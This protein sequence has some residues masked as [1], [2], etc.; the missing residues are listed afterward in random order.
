MRCLRGFASLALALALGCAGPAGDGGSSSE[1]ES[2]SGVPSESGTEAVATESESESESETGETEGDPP[3][4]ARLL[5]TADWRAKRVSLIDYAALRDGAESRD[6]ALWKSLELPDHEPGPL[7]V[8]LTP[9]GSLAVI[10]SSPGFFAGSGGGLVGL[11]EELPIGGGLLIVDVESEAVLAEL[12]TAHYPMGIVISPDGST[13]WTAN[14]GGNGQSGT[15][16]SVIDLGSF[17]ITEELE[18]G[19]GPEQI[20]LSADGGLGMVNIASNGAIRVFEAGNPSGTLSP[21]VVVSEDPSWVLFLDDGM[22]RAVAINSLGPPGYSL[23]DVAD[24]SAPVVLDTVSV[25]GVAYAVASGRSLDEILLAVFTGISISLQMFDVDDGEMIELIEAPITGL[26]LGIAFDP[27]DEIAM[28]PAPAARSLIVAD[29]ASGEYR[30][31][32]WQDEPGPTY[33]SL[34]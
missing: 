1:S 29:F 24:P 12:E 15:T 8:E 16:I 32:D 2:E 21:D 10:A 34:E 6:D 14:Y 22:D 11:S 17:T 20:D 25:A 4:P 5:A 7:E 31:I 27:D 19:P 9:D 3:R 28:V 13:A 23:L 33:V 30:V 26:P 18:V